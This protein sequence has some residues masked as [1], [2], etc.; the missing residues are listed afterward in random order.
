MCAGS[1]ADLYAS[2]GGP[3][4]MAGKPYAPMADL[5]RSLAGPTGIAV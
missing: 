4:V 1:L 5:V 3:V 2:M